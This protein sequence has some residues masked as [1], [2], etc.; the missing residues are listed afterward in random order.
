MDREH[1]WLPKLAPHLS[2]EVPDPVEVGEPDL[3]YP[4]RWLLYRWIDGED[5]GVGGVGDWCDLARDAAEFVRELQLV[6]SEGATLARNRGRSLEPHDEAVRRAIQAMGHEIDADRALALWDE[7]LHAEPWTGPPVWVHGDLLPGNLLVRDGRLVGVIDWS[8]TGIGDPAC[9]TML[10]WAMPAEARAV[11]RESLGLDDATW[12]RGRGW[13]IEQAVK[14]IPYYATT[15]PKA[16]EA[17]R[18]RLETVLA[19]GHALAER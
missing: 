1:A 7:A 4:F 5:A 18:F 11:Y 14:F 12:A 10:A 17:A 8:A 6:D 15:I 19:E 2:V 16:V 13:T 3:D 9:E